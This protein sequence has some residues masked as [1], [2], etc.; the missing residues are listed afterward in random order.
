MTG[1]NYGLITGFVAI[2]IA[3]TA[4]GIAGQTMLNT[5]LATDLA[6]SHPGGQLT[7]TEPF[8]DTDLMQV[9]ADL[10]LELI[11][12]RI[13]Y[14][15]EIV[16]VKKDLQKAQIGTGDPERDELDVQR[17]TGTS[18]KITITLDSSEFIRGE[19]I[20]ISGTGEPLQ[21]IQATI[22]DPNLN[23]RFPNASIDRN[24]SF[25]IAYTTDF[26]SLIGTY[27]VYVKSQGENSQ[28]LSFSLKE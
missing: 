28:T 5:D 19:I 2:V 9:I 15:K 16:Q 26:D 3:V 12:Q 17:G 11:D 4:L 21:Q 27:T 7:H 20:W 10:E 8:D 13:E 18:P 6:H 24:G 23:K 22:T 14:T 25:K 1:I